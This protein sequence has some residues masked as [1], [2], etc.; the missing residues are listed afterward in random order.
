MSSGVPADA[1]DRIDA[2][3]QPFLKEFRELSSRR[4]ILQEYIEAYEA[5]DK[6][7]IFRIISS[8]PR[9][10]R[11]SDHEKTLTKDLYRYAQAEL[12]Q[13]QLGER[14]AQ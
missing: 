13:D 4:A 7:A 6:Y 5:D 11:L 8:N 14:E 10:F 3:I 12:A 1:Y 2:N 9:V